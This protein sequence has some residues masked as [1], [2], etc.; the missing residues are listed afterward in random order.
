M[1]EVIALLVADIHLSH[2]PPPARAAESDW[3]AAMGRP[4]GQLSDLANRYDAPVIC[5]GDV[6]EKWNSP[7]ELVNFAIKYLPKM[8]AIPGQH[9][10]PYHSYDEIRKSAYWTLVE[11]NAII[12]I[13]HGKSCRRTGLSLRLNPAV[14]LRGFPYGCEIKPARKLLKGL[15]SIVIA[16]SYVWVQGH[17]YPGAPNERRLAGYEDRLAG[18]DVA[19]FGDNHKGFLATAGGCNVI[20]CGC[21]IPRKMDER[22]HKP[23]VGLLYDDGLVKFHFLDISEDK[24]AGTEPDEG[25][26]MMGDSELDEFL[27]G[28]GSLGGDSLDFGEAVRRYL[29]DHKVGENTRKALLWALEDG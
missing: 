3:Y 27:E 17:G 25:I 23:A 10:L 22:G 1:S 5:A 15:F 9:D 28:L 14:E 19:V 13:G 8:F 12:D 20:N 29:D 6:F 4:L 16:H 26:Y 24:W 11:A 7:P 18:Y 21:L 2:N